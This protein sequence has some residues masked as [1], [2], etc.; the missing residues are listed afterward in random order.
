MIYQ[1]VVFDN[2]KITKKIMRVLEEL[3]LPIK[4]VGEEKWKESLRRIRKI[5]L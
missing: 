4:Y 1:Y 2:V 5:K 3:A